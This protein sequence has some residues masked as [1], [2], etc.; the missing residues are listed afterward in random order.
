MSPKYTIVLMVAALAAV[1]L[2]STTTVPDN[3]ETLRVKF[4]QWK[5][6]YD[7]SFDATEEMYRF[8]VFVENLKHIEAHNA[9]P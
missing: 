3:N 4:D 7:M 6:E 8:G 5:S 9:K 2:F 1:V